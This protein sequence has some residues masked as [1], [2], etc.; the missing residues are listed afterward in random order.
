M[1]WI[2]YNCKKK[3]ANSFSKIAINCTITDIN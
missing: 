2:L 1:N 3:C